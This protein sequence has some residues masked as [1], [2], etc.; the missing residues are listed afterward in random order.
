MHQTEGL[1][2]INLSKPAKDLFMN[3][4]TLKKN[5]QAAGINSTNNAGNNPAFPL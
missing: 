2:C 5:L 1:H 3:V 4:K